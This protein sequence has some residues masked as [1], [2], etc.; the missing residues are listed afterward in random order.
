MNDMPDIPTEVPL[1]GNKFQPS[2]PPS[3]MPVV[4]KAVHAQHAPCPRQCPHKH[5]STPE[6]VNTTV[7]VSTNLPDD[8]TPQNMTDVKQG[9]K[10]HRT[11][12]FCPEVHDEFCPQTAASCNINSIA[13]STTSMDSFDPNAYTI[14]EQMKKNKLRRAILAKFCDCHEKLCTEIHV[15]QQD[16][17]S[18]L[19]KRLAFYESR[20]EI[21]NKELFVIYGKNEAQRR[22]A[23]YVAQK[24]GMHGTI[25]V[26]DCDRLKFAQ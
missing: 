16:D 22:L 25:C 1:S 11:E 3:L 20:Q 6:G 8:P 17:I 2:L 7:H 14:T 13:H 23:A 24:S 26:D 12:V 15:S 4:N 5:I 9:N 21:F 18:R 10:H 19:E